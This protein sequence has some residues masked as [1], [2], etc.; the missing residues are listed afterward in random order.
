MSR[1][2]PHAATLAAVG[3]ALLDQ[4]VKLAM[5]RFFA[6]HGPTRL[7]PLAD[8]VPA[9]NTGAFLSLGS[10]LSVEAR[11]AVFTIA[12]GLGLAAGFVYLA[13]G[14]ALGPLVRWGLALV[15]G[16]GL[17]NLVDRLFRG[18]RVF[19]FV[20]LHAGPLH[21]GVFN[22]ADVALTAGALVLVVS[23]WRPAPAAPAA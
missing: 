3:I 22:L 19:D 7:G 14:R 15:V 10:G 9:E 13:R 4:L 8:L 12:T 11:A 5:R 23:A 1:L 2:R 6:V 17:G 18:G 16:G 20:V 21:T